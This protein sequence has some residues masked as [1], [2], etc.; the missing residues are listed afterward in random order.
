MKTARKKMKRIYRMHMDVSFPA[1]LSQI[2]RLSR[3]CD[4][5]SNQAYPLQSQS[6]CGQNF[7]F[8]FLLFLMWPE[9]IIGIRSFPLNLS[10]SLRRRK[11]V[12]R[13][14]IIHLRA[15]VSRWIWLVEVM[16]VGWWTSGVLG[17]RVARRIT[18]QRTGG[19]TWLSQ[20]NCAVNR[21]ESSQKVKQFSKF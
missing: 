20:S 19:I 13:H 18:S 5:I 8:L 11:L 15:V 3:M 17:G 14:K 21:W 9:H 6:C 4:R 10:T 2:C 16:G 12:C 7:P 1:N